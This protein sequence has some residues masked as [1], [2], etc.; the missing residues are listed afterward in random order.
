MFCNNCGCPCRGNQCPICGGEAG[1]LPYRLPAPAKKRNKLPVLIL[2]ILALAGIVLF[3]LS[4]GEPASQ[5]GSS[6]RED[7]FLI[8]DGILSFDADAYD[9]GPVLTIPETVGGQTV[10]AISASCFEDVTGITTIYL[11]DT[12]EHLYDRAFAGCSDLRGLELPYSCTSIGNRV[13]EDCVSLESL[14]IPNT[15]T[16][17]GDHT[18]DGCAN[19]LYIFYAGKYRDWN[20]MYPDYINPFCWVLCIDGEYRQ[21]SR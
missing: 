18:F 21:G 15:V 6:L 9:G 17:I 11:P 8:Q 5:P 2:T 13:F 19:L 3:F 14:F 16:Y 12:I 4:P 1:P 7:W 20:T 10:T